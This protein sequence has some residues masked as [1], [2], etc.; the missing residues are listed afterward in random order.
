MTADNQKVIEKLQED[1]KQS[2]QAITAKKFLIHQ[3]KQS[4]KKPFIE[5]K[6]MRGYLHTVKFVTDPLKKLNTKANRALNDP[7][8]LHREEML[9]QAKKILDTC[10]KIQ[11]VG[12]EKARMMA[13]KAAMVETELQGETLRGVWEAGE[14][15]ISLLKKQVAR[16][17]VPADQEQADKDAEKAKELQEVLSQSMDSLRGMIE[18]VQQ[19]A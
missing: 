14:N 8:G 2:K 9:I 18:D 3:L 12:N 11:E 4:T 15:V 7:I 6:F 16:L 19:E 17:R 5:S 1:I 13:A 10:E